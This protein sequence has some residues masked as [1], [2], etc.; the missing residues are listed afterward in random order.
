[1]EE[2]DC[3]TSRGAGLKEFDVY[4]GRSRGIPPPAAPTA[5]SVAPSHEAVQRDWVADLSTTGSTREEALRDLHGLLLRAAAHQVSRMRG[6]LVGVDAQAIDIVVNQAA[7]EATVAVLKKLHTFEGRSR[8][9]TWA[10]KFALVQAACDV[11]RTAWRH[12]DVELR[13]ADT[14]RDRRAGPEEIAAGGELK[15]AI[16]TALDTALTPHQRRVAIALLIDEVPVDVLA[17]RL[18][19]N[20]GALYK[21]LHDARTRLRA[22]LVASGFLDNPSTTAARTPHRSRPEQP[23]TGKDAGEF[24][25]PTP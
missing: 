13:D 6:Q 19:T 18:G 4:N 14:L 21:T 20:R 9:T 3:S 1:M 15:E 5:G 11:R 16:I 10:Y 8:F 24:A 22:A 7:D 2:K 12:R 23:T 17:E 25:P